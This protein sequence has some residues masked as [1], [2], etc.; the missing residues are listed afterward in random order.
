MLQKQTKQDRWAGPSKEHSTASAGQDASAGFYGE[1]F[2]MSKQVEQKATKGLTF[3]SVSEGSSDEHIL[4]GLNLPIYMNCPHCRDSDSKQGS[5][6]RLRFT[7]S[8]DL[9]G[10]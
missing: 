5:F 4:R 10:M 2:D 3:M 8:T 9:F 6:C 7:A 1:T